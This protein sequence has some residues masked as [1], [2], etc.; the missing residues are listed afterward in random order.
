MDTTSEIYEAV[1]SLWDR[2]GPDRPRIRLLGVSVSG[3]SA[4]PPKRQLSLVPEEEG[5]ALH[6]SDAAEAI[7]SI[8]SRFGTDAVTP[9]TLLDDFE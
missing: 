7:D 3:L 8:R 9:A 4:G 1:G 5:S 2:I 6:R